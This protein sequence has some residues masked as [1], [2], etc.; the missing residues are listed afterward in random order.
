MTLEDILEHSG[1]KRRSGRYPWG[2]GEHPYQGESHAFRAA[3]GK[4]S[5]SS[6]AK[7][8]KEPKD[9]VKMQRKDLIK[10]KNLHAMSPDDL[11]KMIDRLRK[12]KEL[13]N[14]VESDIAPGKKI[15]KEIMAEV[16]KQTAKEVL[17]G[18]TRYV[19]NYSLQDGKTRKFSS[20]DLARAIYPNLNKQDDQ[21]K[22][23]ESGK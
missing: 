9:P 6:K 1:V 3:H 15:M 7:K 2:S 17:T 22:K 4:S 18:T 5:T 8:T 11:Q 12:E 14:L 21:K 13:K 20:A 16:G 23:K 10:S 19:I